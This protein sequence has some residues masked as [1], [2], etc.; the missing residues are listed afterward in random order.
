MDEVLETPVETVETPTIETPEPSGEIT[1]PETPATP[2]YES[3]FAD[4]EPNA[5][6]E[7]PPVA[8]EFAKVLGIS[9]YVREPAHVEAAVR[10]AGEVWDVVSGKS[11]ASAL[12]EGMRSQNPTQYEK[13]VREDLIP[14]IEKI[15]GQK[16]GAQAE[17]KSPEQQRIDALEAQWNQQR[18]AEQQAQIQQ[19]VQRASAVLVQK[20]DEA[21]KGTWLEGRAKDILGEL[22]P[23]MGMSEEQAVKALLS[24]NT[25][26]VDKAV[27]ALLEQKEAQGR[28]YS[29]WKIAESRKLKTGVPAG[30]GNP[31]SGEPELEAMTREQR[32]AYLQS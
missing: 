14:Y 31:R 3:L 16:F 21:L 28:A 8:D 5:T 26:M 15:T 32:I 18:Q 6:P 30:K 27:K 10:T 2:D 11:Q 4:P 22:A 20:A 29:R 7:T 1:Q 17:P 25:A 19:Q 23:H 13:T 12:L 9:E 24:G